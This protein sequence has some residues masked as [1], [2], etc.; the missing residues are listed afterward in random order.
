MKNRSTIR[1]SVGSKYRLGRKYGFG[2]EYGL[3]N[4]IM[5]RESIR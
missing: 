2:S 1:N 5:V 3:G 4:K